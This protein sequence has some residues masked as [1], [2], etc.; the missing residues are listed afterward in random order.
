M[1]YKLISHKL[2]F[3]FY[4]FKSFIAFANSS[5]LLFASFL[6]ADNSSASFSQDFIGHVFSFCK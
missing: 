6:A 2:V 5:S 1:I 3:V 4:L